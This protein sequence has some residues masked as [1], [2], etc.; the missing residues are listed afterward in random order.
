MPSLGF[1]EIL[2]ILLLALLIFGPRRL[3]EMGRTIGRSL[4]EFRRAASDLRAEIEEDL[5]DEPPRVP[6]RAARKTRARN[7]SPP[8]AP[9]SGDGS[10]P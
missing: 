3:P 10:T 4:K 7:E 1:G 6:S 2:V 5:D 8:A 9:P